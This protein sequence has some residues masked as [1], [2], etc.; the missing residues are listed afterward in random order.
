M[1]RRKF[2]KNI[3]LLSSGAFMLNNVPLRAL[4]ANSALNSMMT[5]ESDRVLVFI[6]L[7]GGND[8]LN[9][10]IPRARYSEYYNLRPN[11]AI[12][13]SG[14]R[15]YIT[16][17]ESAASGLQVGLHP[18]LMHIK[19]MYDNGMMAVVQNVG[20]EN[21]NMSHFRSRDIWFMGGDYNDYF[22]SGWMGR[23]LETQYPGYPVNF[24]NDNM[25]DPL[26][27][28]MGNDVSIAFHRSKGIPAGISIAN[29]DAFY[30]LIQKVCIE[31]PQQFT[32]NLH[33]HEMEY[34]VDMERKTNAYSD[35]LKE[36]YDRGSNQIEYPET[37]PLAAPARFLANPLAPQLKV[38]SRLL[39][40]GSKTRVFLARIGGFDTHASQVETY[41]ATM[42]IHAALLH[43]VSA[44]VKAFFDD[45]K[46]HGL[47][48]KVLAV[49][50]TEFGRRAASNSSYGTDHGKATP[51]MLFGKNLNAGIY[52]EN[53]DLSDL[54]RGNLRYKYD[55]RQIY[56]SILTDWMQVSQQ[57][58]NVSYFSDF[59]GYSLPLFSDNTGIKQHQQ[60]VNVL[61]NCYPNP[62]TTFTNIRFSLFTANNVQLNIYTT[63]GKLIR[64]VAKQPYAAGNHEIQVDISGFQR[65]VYIVRLKLD[66]GVW[67]KKLIVG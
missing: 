21:I 3:S 25:P 35:R 64:K 52:G 44:S 63:G 58:Y 38:I 26:G 27:L 10:I 16:L 17:D 40:G 31:E 33:G 41:D 62:A 46:A 8:G 34:L 19:E 66:K 7:H 51:V 4:A 50:M 65:G 20:Y 49:T 12:P 56:S 42:G 1:N 36:V 37:Y 39:S 55:Y 48:D 54:D 14:A 15:K 6:Q 23:M 60:V 59:E 53:P 45:L 28:E 47:D 67:V 13:E 9:T 2:I 22:N 11:V 57:A 30:Y 18:E 43:H 5:E 29:P 61:H 24:P 32:D